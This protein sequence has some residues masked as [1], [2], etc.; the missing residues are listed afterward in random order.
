MNKNKI[1]IIKLIGTPK[2]FPLPIH[3]KNSDSNP[4]ITVPL[5][6][7]NAPPASIE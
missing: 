7:V 6:K 1:I 2:Y 5:V 3:L 4:N